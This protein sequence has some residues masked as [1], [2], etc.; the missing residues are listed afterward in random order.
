MSELLPCPFCGGEAY[1]IGYTGTRE[2]RRINYYTVRCRKCMCETWENDTE[3]EAIEAWNT[4][5]ERTCKFGSEVSAFD[6]TL[7]MLADI[8]WY[9]CLGCGAATPS[10]SN[11]CMHC[12]AKVVD[13]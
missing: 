5:A 7:N 1:I 12:G 10:I 4:R 11:Y 13:E 3:A 6:V 9:W 2:C 8:P